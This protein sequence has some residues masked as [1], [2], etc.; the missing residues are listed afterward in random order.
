M[1]TESDKKIL[2]MLRNN[3]RVTLTKL[4]RKT[5]IPVSTIYDRIKQHNDGVIKK[6]TVIIDFERLGYSARA[7]IA[8]KVEKADRIELSYFLLKHRNVNSA[9]R[10]T[11]G[12]D[13]IIE[14]IFKNQMELNDFNEELDK[15]FKISQRQIYYILEDIKR[16]EFMPIEYLD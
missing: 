16:E 8:L 6:H 13:F 9:Y 14:G 4:S 10:T 12:F 2:T 11:N 5:G 15:N 3:A 7:N 1:L